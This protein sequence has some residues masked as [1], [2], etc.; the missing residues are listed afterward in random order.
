MLSMSPQAG[1]TARKVRPPRAYL[2]CADVPERPEVGS[3]GAV[4]G[5][6]AAIPLKARGQGF[7]PTGEVAR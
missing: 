6:D 4:E 3:E 7:G 5:G 1:T 2:T